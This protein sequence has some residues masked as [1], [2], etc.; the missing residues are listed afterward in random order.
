VFV[1]AIA[2]A[3][4]RMLL[5]IILLL[6]GLVTEL[7]LFPLLGQGGRDFCIKYWSKSILWVAGVRMKVRG[8]APT[9]ACQI[10][11]NHSSWLDILTINSVQ[12]SQFVAK[13]E[14]RSWP[15]VGLLV[16]RA[17]THFIERSKR[18]A[19]HTVLQ[20]IVKAL[21][22]GRTVAVFPEGTTNDGARLLPFHA[23]L[24]QAAL[25]A[26]VPLKP[27]AIGYKNSE[28]QLSEALE[29][30]GDTTFVMSLWRVMQIPVIYAELT[31]GEE[32]AALGT[33]H[34]LC[35]QVEW[36]ISELTGLGM[37]TDRKW[38]HPNEVRNSDA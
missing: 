19:V 31:W 5:L 33:R 26:A 35:K 29:Y 30:I 28:G 18:R 24:I 17:G 37:A 6:A 27:L 21:Q 1:L 15:V 14:I 20:G 9:Q 2:R 10:A 34:E 16:A 8:R 3:I 36:Q 23:N 32:V 13:A 11:A 12:A 22:A 25:D 4:V 7:M 38:Q